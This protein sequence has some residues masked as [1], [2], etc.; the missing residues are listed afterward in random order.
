MIINDQVQTLKCL[1]FGELLFKF[2]TISDS[3]DNVNTVIAFGPVSF[4]V[5]IIYQLCLQ[6]NMVPPYQP[7]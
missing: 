1:K 4:A 6:R 2:E 5:S 7:W 3:I